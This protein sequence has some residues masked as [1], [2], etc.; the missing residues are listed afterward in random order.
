MLWTGSRVTICWHLSVFASDNTGVWYYGRTMINTAYKA[1]VLACGARQSATLMILGSH[2]CSAMF[3]NARGDFDNGRVS[4]ADR[5]KG[6]PCASSGIYTHL[7]NNSP[8]RRIC[9]DAGHRTMTGIEWYFAARKAAQLMGWCYQLVTMAE[10][11][12]LHNTNGK[13]PPTCVLM[14]TNHQKMSCDFRNYYIIISY[15]CVV[16]FLLEKWLVWG[17]PYWRETKRQNSLLYETN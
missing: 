7:L 4:W 11:S 16:V 5:A 9:L 8:S 10:R 3:S 12:R 6:V 2:W 1:L 14:C 13:T 17:R 15:D